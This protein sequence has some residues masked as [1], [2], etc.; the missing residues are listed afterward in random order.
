MA[1]SETYRNTLT[2]ALAIAGNERLLA[3]RLGVKVQQV[4]N[5]T[6][7]I[8]QVPTNIFLKAVDV[9][10]AATADDI[11]RSRATL[12]KLK[13]QYKGAANQRDLLSPDVRLD[14]AAYPFTRTKPLSGKPD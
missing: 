7:G 13:F 9:V 4:L 14:T 1:H 2:Y 12:D 5:W 10:L 6:M 11:K 3:E 8:E